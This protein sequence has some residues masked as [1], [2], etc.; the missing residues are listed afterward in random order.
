M[1]RFASCLCAGALL[2]LGACDEVP[3]TTGGGGQGGDGGGGG[4]DPFA[5]GEPLDVD[6]N[7]GRAYVDLDT[8]AIVAESDA[9][10][11][12]IDGREVYTNGGVSGSGKG[13]AFPIDAPVFA[14]DTVPADVPFLIED[15]SGGP[16]VDWYVYDGG[17]HQV[18]SRYHVFG[19]RRGEELYK[20]QILSFYGEVE[21]APVPAV[22]QLRSARVTDAGV[23]ETVL[24]VNVDGTAGGAGPEPS[25]PSGCLRL[26][27]DERFMLTPE[28]AKSSSDWDLC[29]RRDAVLLNG[30]TGGA[31]GIDAVDLQASESAGET[32]ADVMDLTPESELPAFDAVAYTD[33]TDASLSYRTDGVVTAFTDKWIEPGS[34]PLEPGMLAFLVA[35]A[36]GE[37]PFFV[38]FEKL[39]G[40][41]AESPGIVTM[42]IKAIGGSLP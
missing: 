16:F 30:G 9:W 39:T 3:E 38:A 21:G 33:L 13:A 42:R 4:G 5:S 35:G 22:Y 2:A 11:V 18:Y 20:V 34:N 6:S 7:A 36:D 17:T 28:E 10:D 31:V 26:A 25:E 41:T 23:E 19:V 14:D 27:T 40:A 29:F 24:H 37:T 32:L 12:V 1:N 15:Q 8:V